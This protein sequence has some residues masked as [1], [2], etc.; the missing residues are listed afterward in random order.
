MK[1]DSTF[2]ELRREIWAILKQ[3]AG[4][5]RKQEKESA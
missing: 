3:G 1:T 5:V 2:L 4:V